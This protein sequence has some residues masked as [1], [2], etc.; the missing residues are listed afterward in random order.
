MEPD[1][2]PTG[3]AT[4]HADTSKPGISLS[5]WIKANPV[6]SCRTEGDDGAILFN[7]DTDSTLLI[8]P[9]GIIVWNFLSKPRTV[10]EIVEYITNTFSNNP[11]LTSI[12]KDV[13]S[14]VTDL[15]PDFIAEVLE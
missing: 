14:F 13:E 1:T 9:T 8:N 12:R 3:P 5:G 7:A 2:P 15:A 11:D 6:V 4:N 10:E